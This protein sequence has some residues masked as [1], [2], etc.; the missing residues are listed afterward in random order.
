M[1]GYQMHIVMGTL[2]SDPEIRHLDGGSR[3]AT[4][5]VAVNESYTDKNTN[6]RKTKTEWV[7]IEAWGHLADF[8]STQAKKGSF[9]FIEGKQKT[10]QWTDENGQTRSMTKTVANRIQHTQPLNAN[11]NSAQGQQSAPQAQPQQP[12][13]QAAPAPVA[14]PVAQQPAPQQVA[15]QQTQQYVTNEQFM[16][17]GE[18]SDDLPF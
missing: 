18:G 6:E 4:V 10:D 5:S 16:S 1:N 3:V 11:G 7:R 14:Q 12:A 17:G 9:L 13:Q 15:Q 2:G 8:L